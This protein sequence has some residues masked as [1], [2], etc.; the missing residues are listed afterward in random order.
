MLKFSEIKAEVKRRATLDQ[1]GTTYDTAITNI[2]NTSL[3]RTARERPWRVLRR[4]N[5]FNTQTSYTTGTGAVSVTAG[6]TS[7]SVVG[8]TFLTDQIQIGRQVKFG[9]DSTYYTI[10]TITSETAGTI[11]RAY[12]GTTSTTTSYEIMPTETYNLPVQVNPTRDFLWHNAYGYPMQLEY[13]VEQDFRGYNINDVTVAK[14]IAYRM[15]NQDMVLKQLTQPSVIRVVSSSSSDTSKNITVFGI[16]SGYPD[17][18]VI[19]T[20]G[21]N[22]TTAV[23]G[24]KSFSSV[25]RISKAATTVGRITVDANSGNDVVAVIPVGLTTLGPLYP[26]VSLF[27]LPDGVYPININYYKDPWALVNDDDIHE[28]GQEFDEAIILLSVAKIQYQQ[29]KLTDGDKFAALYMD[30]IKSLA[31]VNC[32]KIDW[33]PRLKRPQDSRSGRNSRI[34]R[35]LSYLQIGTGGQFGPIGYR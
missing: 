6:S 28:M 35:G 31:K 16:V 14:P 3:F 12:G 17:Y 15:W 1:S 30:E 25:E 13:I 22:G 10:R 2:V 23:S 5:Y 18:E 26:K 34:S 21:S 33:F 29:S 32:D 7:F 24:T 11:D 20:N 19:T 8:A 4:S 27:P 9:T